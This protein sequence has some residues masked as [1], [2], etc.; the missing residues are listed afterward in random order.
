MHVTF[1]RIILRSL[2]SVVPETIIK[3]PTAPVIDNH[4]TCTDDPT[5]LTQK[6]PFSRTATVLSNITPK[7][8]NYTVKSV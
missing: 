6:Q 7:L 4:N 8:L 2:T 3:A 5:F 1:S